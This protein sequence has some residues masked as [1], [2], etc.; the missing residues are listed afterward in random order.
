MPF[1]SFLAELPLS[2]RLHIFSASQTCVH[3]QICWQPFPS[4][5]FYFVYEFFVIEDVSQP[6]TIEKVL[7]EENVNL[8]CSD[9]LKDLNNC[10]SFLIL[11][12]KNHSSLGNIR[13]FIFL[14]L[15]FR[16]RSE[17][18]CLRGRGEME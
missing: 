8:V 12:L 16:L 5:W 15:F 4:L 18:Q 6:D 7:Q 14:P 3:Q 1:A 9:R 11:W 2:R 10:S 13:I 17:R